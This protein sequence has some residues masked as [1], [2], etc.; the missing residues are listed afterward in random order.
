MTTEEKWEELRQWVKKGWE[1]TTSENY[2]LRTSHGKFMDSKHT[3]LQELMKMFP[4][5]EEFCKK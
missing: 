3:I 1:E 2:D 4:E 5:L